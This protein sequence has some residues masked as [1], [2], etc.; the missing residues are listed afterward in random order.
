MESPIFRRSISMS[1]EYTTATELFF[2]VS[3]YEPILIDSTLPIFTPLILTA[4][5]HLAVYA[6]GKY[7]MHF[8]YA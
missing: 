7:E 5:Q 8:P 2:I 6:F 4:L 3:E 1:I